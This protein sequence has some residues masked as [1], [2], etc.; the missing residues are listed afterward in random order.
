[1]NKQGWGLKAELIF[2]L[3]FLICLAFSIIGLN[4]FG[5]LI[6][7]NGVDPEFNT[8]KE[9]VDDSYTF[10]EQKLSSAARSYVSNFYGED[11]IENSLT[12][13]YN[14]L[15][16]S[17]FIGE[18]SDSLNRKCSGYVIVK[19]LD[20]TLVYYPYLNCKKYQTSGYES[21]KDW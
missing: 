17:N 4:K 2:I 6:N 9:N 10:L 12:V 13:R 18:I 3:L 8:G 15:Y 7:G 14:T 11:R 1:M 19:V 5:L 16:Y 21:S 20:N